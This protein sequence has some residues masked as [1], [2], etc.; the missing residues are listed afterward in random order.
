[1]NL[2]IISGEFPPFAGGAG[3]YCNYLVKALVTLGHKITLITKHYKKNNIQEKNIDENLAK[4]NVKCIRMPYSKFTFIFSW[5]KI[6]FHVF[7]VQN[8][9]N[10]FETA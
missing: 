10:F 3:T 8:N 2:L 5:Y 1:M 9:F 7:M 6:Y 4:Q